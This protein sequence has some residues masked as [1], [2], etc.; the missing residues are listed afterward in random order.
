ML[1][2]PVR[3]SS[4]HDLPRR[5]HGQCPC[6]TWCRGTQETCFVQLKQ[7]LRMWSSAPQRLSSRVKITARAQSTHVRQRTDSELTH[8]STF[9]WPGELFTVEDL[10]HC[11][12]LHP[13]ARPQGSMVSC[14][15]NR[16]MAGHL[17][18]PGDKKRRIEGPPLASS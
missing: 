12:Q 15:R 4:P 17:R 8:G 10:V 7:C 13:T 2:H 3:Q 14:C 16:T 18:F 9:R 6:V 11:P 5:S 1:G